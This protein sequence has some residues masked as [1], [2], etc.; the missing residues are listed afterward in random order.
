MSQ[1][2]LTWG[3]GSHWVLSILLQRPQPR[4]PPLRALQRMPQSP[5]WEHLSVSTAQ[6]PFPHLL[7][8][9]VWLF[10]GKPSCFL[11]QFY[12]ISCR[13]TSNQGSRRGIIRGSERFNSKIFVRIIEKR[14]FFHRSWCKPE[15]ASSHLVWKWNQREQNRGE[16]KSES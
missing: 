11:F 6:N 1:W 14:P 16:R 3:S 9:A 2:S 12:V 5:I 10:L 7:D 15:A 13:Q 4:S 8:S